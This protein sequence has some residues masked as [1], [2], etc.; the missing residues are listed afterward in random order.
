MPKG[1]RTSIPYLPM[2]AATRPKT[3]MGATFMTM[4]VSLNMA[5]ETP[6]RKST[7]GRPTAPAPARATP[8]STEKK[9]MG[10]SSPWAADSRMLVGM[11][12]RSIWTESWCWAVY[13]E[14]SVLASPSIATPWPG[15]NR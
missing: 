14:T 1:T 6:C 3:P 12:C 11:M 15:R 8:K 10:S 9:M 4:L 7:T 13:C 2:V 5:S